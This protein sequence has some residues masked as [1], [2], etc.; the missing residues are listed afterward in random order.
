M[1]V[2]EDDGSPRGCNDVWKA[3]R[4]DEARGEEDDGDFLQIV[5]CRD[6]GEPPQPPEPARVRRDLH[7]GEHAVWVVEVWHASAS[8]NS[9]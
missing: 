9:V 7:V 1:V 3:W 8:A 2:L 5:A 6:N 4:K